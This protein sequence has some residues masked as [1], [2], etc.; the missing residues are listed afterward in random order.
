M[1]CDTYFGFH[2]TYVRVLCVCVCCNSQRNASRNIADARLS[3]LDVQ[4][5]AKTGQ[6]CNTTICMAVSLTR[7]LLLLDSTYYV[8]C[9]CACV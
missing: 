5:T 1:L 7:V 6:H 4:Q 8:V 9:A 2:I 3:G